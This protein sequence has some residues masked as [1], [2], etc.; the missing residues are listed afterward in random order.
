MTLVSND[1]SWWPLINGNVIFSYFAVAASV[2]VM[3][4]WAL[5]FGRELELIW[6][7][8]WSLMTFLYLSVRYAGIAHA[9]MNILISVPTISMTDAVSLI[10]NDELDWMA[11]IVNVILGVIMIVR[12]HAVYQRS[13]KVLIFLVVIFLAIRI[14]NAVMTVIITMQS[15]GEEFVLSGTY[16]CMFDSG[17]DFGFLGSMTWILDIVWEV[18]ALCLAVWIA[19]KHFRELRQHSK[20]IIGDCFT[21]LMET[22]VSYFARSVLSLQRS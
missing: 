3:Y 11:D 21:V 17:G 19:V 4:D 22:H 8:R 5:T 9:V 16:Q 12:L 13:R 6:R 18:V 15:S 2:G 14:A 7:Q 10:I 20:G 1:P